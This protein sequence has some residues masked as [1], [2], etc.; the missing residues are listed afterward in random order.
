MSAPAV[1][2]ES[3]LPR[4][5]PRVLLVLVVLSAAFTIGVMLWASGYGQGRAID[6]EATSTSA[7]LAWALLPF[8]VAGVVVVVG[9]RGARAASVVVAIGVVALA[10]LTVVLLLS[11][12]ASESS[13]AALLFVFLP[14]YQLLVIGAAAV[15]AIVIHLLVRQR[16]AHGTSPGDRPE[17]GVL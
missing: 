8:L 7:F 12:L 13:T 17:R 2:A 9:T 10:V 6:D 11:F 5:V 14:V 16:R 1:Q 3:R 4:A 15:A